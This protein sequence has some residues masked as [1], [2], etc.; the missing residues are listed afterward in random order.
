MGMLLGSKSRDDFDYEWIGF[1][2]EVKKDQKMSD[3]Q[4]MQ[5]IGIPQQMIDEIMSI[6]I[7]E[8]GIFDLDRFTSEGEL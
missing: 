6:D 3:E 1:Q 2:K 7:P 8:E 4:Y 5:L